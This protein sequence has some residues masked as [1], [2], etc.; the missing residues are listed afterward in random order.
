MGFVSLSSSVP[1]FSFTSTS[2]DP[3]LLKYIVDNFEIER[4]TRAQ[5]DNRKIKHTKTKWNGTN[6][7]EMGIEK[8][9]GIVEWNSRTMDSHCDNLSMCLNGGH[10]N[11]P[12]RYTLTHRIRSSGC[13]SIWSLQRIIIKLSSCFSCEESFWP[14][15]VVF[16]LHNFVTFHTTSF[17]CNS[18][19]TF[20]HFPLDRSAI[21]V[22]L[23]DNT[24]SFRW[25][26]LKEM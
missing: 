20:H 7:T 6:Q 19:I 16:F 4:V 15:S 22:M 12:Y 25:L 18:K 3:K 5:T 1:W 14:F 21:K 26:L 9:I 10:A 11:E 13:A 8:K 23:H 24:P 2:F 17:Y